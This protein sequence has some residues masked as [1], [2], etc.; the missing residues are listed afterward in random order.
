MA[1]TVARV[2]L[3]GNVRD[4]Q[5]QSNSCYKLYSAKNAVLVWG[6]VGGGGERLIKNLGSNLY[7]IAIAQDFHY[8]RFVPVELVRPSRYNPQK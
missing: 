8:P 1:Y 2:S 4:P 6:G 5:S 7:I 3:I